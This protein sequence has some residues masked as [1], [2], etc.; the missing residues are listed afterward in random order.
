MVRD[1]E[2]IDRDSFADDR[3][4]R[5]MHR[6]PIRRRPWR[7]LAEVAASRAYAR[8]VYRAA[9]TASHPDP[10]S[11]WVYAWMVIGNVARL[12]WLDDDD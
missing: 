2:Q 3:R 8:E 5:D 4:E 12:E 7:T 9:A 10:W 6:E 1:D 11:A